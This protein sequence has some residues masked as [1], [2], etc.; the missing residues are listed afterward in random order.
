MPASLENCYILTCNVNLEDEKTEVSGGFFFSN[1]K[2]REKLFE[3]ERA[4]VDKRVEKLVALKRKLCEGT[5][6]T[7]VIVN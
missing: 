5:N 7:F 4:F 1:A 2:E 6:K 3:A